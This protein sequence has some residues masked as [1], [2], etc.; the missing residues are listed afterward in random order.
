MFG[1]IIDGT[2]K[3]ID[4]YFLNKDH[5]AAAA[6]DGDYGSM[7]V[8]ARD[9]SP[10][11]VSLVPA[12]LDIQAQGQ[13]QEPEQEIQAV[14]NSFPGDIQAQGLGQELE[15]DAADMLPPAPMDT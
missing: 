15:Q 11:D 10:M 4:R 7:D 9:E 1:I 6:V 13:G 5:A 14:V 12:L 3:S 2:R 8:V